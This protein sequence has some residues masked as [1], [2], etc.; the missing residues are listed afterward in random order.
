[1]L[2]MVRS[3]GPVKNF[4]AVVR[5]IRVSFIEV[6]CFPLWLPFQKNKFGLNVCGE[7]GEYETFTL[8]CPLFSKKIVV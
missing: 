4:C 3:A 1:M 2:S 7:G 8:D 5:A 6:F